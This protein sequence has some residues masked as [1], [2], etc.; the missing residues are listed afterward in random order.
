LVLNF[1]VLQALKR[2]YKYSIV[3]WCR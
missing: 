3:A 2:Q 1:T